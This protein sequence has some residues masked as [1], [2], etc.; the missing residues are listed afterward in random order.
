MPPNATRAIW[1]TDATNLHSVERAVGDKILVSLFWNFWVLFLP[2]KHKDKLCCVIKNRPKSALTILRRNCYIIKSIYSSKLFGRLSQKES[3]FYFIP[4]GRT[5]VVSGNL[6]EG[7]FSLVPIYIFLMLWDFW[8]V[9]NPWSNGL[10]S[11][12]IGIIEY[13][14]VHE[15][16]VRIKHN[17]TMSKEE[18]HKTFQILTVLKDT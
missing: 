14:E 13:Y 11:W 15:V 17:K 16:V 4:E 10:L 6:R 12:K 3:L 8:H 1:M 18:L 2:K 9:S 7:E 5:K